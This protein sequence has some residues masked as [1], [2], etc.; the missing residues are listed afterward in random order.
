MLGLAFPICALRWYYLLRIQGIYLRYFQIFKVNYLSTFLGLFLPGAISGDAIR[1]ALGS[2]LLPKQKIVLVLSIFVDRLIGAISLLSLAFAAVII[3]LSQNTTSYGKIAL[4]I[5][6]GLIFI[7]S[8]VAIFSVKLFS[9][10]LRDIART[11]NWQKGN[12]V[13][14]LIANIAESII[15]YRNCPG[16][17][18]LCYGLSLIVH[19]TRLIVIY[20]LAISMGMG[21]VNVFTYVLAGIVS[22]LANF[23]PITPGGLG[24]GEAAFTQIVGTLAMADQQ[25]AYGTVILAI[26]AFDA[27]LLFPAVLMRFEKVKCNLLKLE[28][29]GN[30]NTS[31][32][33]SAPLIS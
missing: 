29:K 13:K 12:F 25:T 17:L 22:F 11:H 19:A 4:S 15:L 20:I 32:V 33:D 18:A 10:R 21:D 31:D 27:I 9:I 7:V 14:R 8:L 26:R 30:S 1:I 5:S 3:F 28:S 16:Q 23:L 2:T 6:V 24:I